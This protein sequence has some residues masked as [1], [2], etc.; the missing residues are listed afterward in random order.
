MAANLTRHLPAERPIRHHRRIARNFVRAQGFFGREED[1][2]VAGGRWNDAMTASQ[3]T[4]TDIGLGRRRAKS[5]FGAWGYVLSGTVNVVDGK[6]D[7]QPV[8]RGLLTEAQDCAH[9][10]ADAVGWDVEKTLDKAGCTAAKRSDP[11]QL[12][13]EQL[14]RCLAFLTWV[15]DAVTALD[16]VPERRL[17]V[18]GA[19]RL[20]KQAGRTVKPGEDVDLFLSVTAQGNPSCVQLLKLGELGFGWQ[21]ARR[22]L[23]GTVGDRARLMWLSS[24]Y[25][26]GAPHLSPKRIRMLVDDPARLGDQVTSAMHQHLAD[27]D[28]CQAAYPEAAER[29]LTSH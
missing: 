20:L 28:A 9:R 26:V 7:E 6:I 24:P 4:D 11:H 21:E 29:E 27:C 17:V 23:P 13:N 16:S 25:A 15:E 8:P 10:L 18:S 22:H 12:E 19:A 14:Q 3:N 1:Y 5:P 2:P